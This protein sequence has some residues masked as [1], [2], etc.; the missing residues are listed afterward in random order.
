MAERLV[1][2]EVAAVFVKDVIL[3]H[4]PLL[5]EMLEGA[6][7]N[8]MHPAVGIGLTEFNPRISVISDLHQAV[9]KL[10]CFIF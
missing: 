3:R 9:D 6:K 2:A 10:D 4:G 7:A 1:L 5:P 8:Q